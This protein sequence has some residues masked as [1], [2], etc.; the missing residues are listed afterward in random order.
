ML[1]IIVFARNMIRIFSYKQSIG[2][3]DNYKIKH[4]IVP[5]EYINSISVREILNDNI[6]DAYNQ[7]EAYTPNFEL[8]EEEEYNILKNDVIENEDPTT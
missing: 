1:Q 2:N 5:E 3:I 8:V 6:P 7:Q 4:S